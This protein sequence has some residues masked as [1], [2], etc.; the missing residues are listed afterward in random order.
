MA[1]TFPRTMPTG[2]VDSQSFDLARTDLMSPVVS[3]R[4][5]GVTAGFPL[6]RMTLT[7]NNRDADETDEWRAWVLAQ[8]GMQ[9]L[10]LGRDLTRPYPKA[11]RSGFAG[12]TRAGGGAFDGPA[13]SWS[14]NADRDVLTL[15]G[16]P[17]GLA[18]TLN[19]YAGFRW[20][21]GGSARR[22]LVRAVEPAVASGAG[23]AIFSIEPPLPVLTPGSA[24][25][26]LA[27]PDCLMRLV[28]GETTIGEIDTLH[29]AGGAVVGVQQLL[30]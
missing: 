13:T 21:T 4:M 26:T 23:V 27:E 10:F 29:S 9:R 15:N 28:P 17:V 12:M 14:V 30:A 5:G 18:L 11:Y 7:L 1:L 19:D 2:G 20:E 16:L 25:A 22:A 3:G 6:W 24:T 8:R